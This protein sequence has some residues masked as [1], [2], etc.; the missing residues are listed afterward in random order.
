M[1]G[2]MIEIEILIVLYPYRKVNVGLETQ[3]GYFSAGRWA[4]QTL[5]RRHPPSCPRKM[6]I[7]KRIRNQELS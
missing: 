6:S 5:G 4:C 3:R 2:A 7:L 1:Q